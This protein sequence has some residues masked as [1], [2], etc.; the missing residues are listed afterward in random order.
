MNGANSLITT[1]R[2]ATD[3]EGKDTYTDDVITSTE[4]YIEPLNAQ[5]AKNYADYDMNLLFLMV[6]DGI[7]DILISDS[8]TDEDDVNY[9]VIG[10]QPYKGGEIPSHTEVVMFK[11]RTVA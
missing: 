9:V 5:A 3:G 4:V 10:V 8:V 1:R 2:F 7:M 6:G 11:K